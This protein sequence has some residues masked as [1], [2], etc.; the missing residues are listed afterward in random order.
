M[1][2]YSEISNRY[3]KENKKRT[4]LTIL[5]ITLATVL[6]FAVGTFL[7]SFKDS[8]IVSERAKSDY[9]FQVRN[10]NSEQAEKVVNNAEVKDSSVYESGEEYSLSAINRKTVLEKG[11]KDYFDKIYTNKVLEGRE[12]EK[13]GEVI[14]DVNVKNILRTK[15]GDEFT[16]TNQEGKI[17]KINIVGISEQKIYTSNGPLVFTGY[18]DNFDNSKNYYI[19]VNL[20]SDKSKQQII[21]KVI[22]TANIEVKDGTKINNSEL[23]YLTGNGPAK[24]ITESL[25][26]MAVFVIVIIMLCTITVIYNSFN[27]SV[28]ERIKY[29]GILKAIGATPKQIK[30][31]IL[32]EGAIMGV[33]A[34][35][36]GCLIGYFSLVIGVKLF[37][38]DSLI[39]VD[40]FKV[41]FYPSIIAVTVALVSVTIWIS[42]LGPA[43]KA[44]KVSA[45]EAMRNKNE[46]KIGKVKRRRGKLVGKIFGIEGSLA[47]KNI[48][49]TPVRFIIT[50]V[51]LTISIIM[52]NVFY[53]F[54]DYAKQYIYQSYGNIFFDSQLGK[55]GEEIFTKN[56]V[57]DIESKS[58]IKNTYEFNLKN[59]KIAISKDYINEDFIEKTGFDKGNEEVNN[60]NILSRINTYI[61]GD[62]ELG[63][64]EKY[65]SEGKFDLE[66]LKNG[67]IILIDGRS[68]THK[69]GTKE[70]VR[71]TNYKVGDK[72]RIPKLNN[73]D[74]KSQ[75][76]SDE[77]IKEAIENNKYYEVPIIAIAQ[78]EPFQGQFLT[79]D[80]VELMIHKDAYNKYFKD[81]SPNGLFFTFDGDKEAREEA[82]K[83]FDE[84]KDSKGYNYTD[85]GSS[86]NQ[87][88]QLFKQA[89][90]FVYCF[91]I[92]ITVISIVNIFNT[93]ST[94]LLLRKKEFATLKAIGMMEKQLRKSVILEGTLYGI[95]ASIVGGIASALLLGLLIKL[96]GGIGDLDYKFGII[97]FVASIVAAIAVTYLSTLIPLRRLKKLTIIEGISDDE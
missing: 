75:E 19:Y 80:E 35:P 40:N 1:K 14:I 22:K 46:I 74:Y 23:L 97:P 45:V 24:G 4:A 11:N 56:E 78:K 21:D 72:I 38:G 58:F 64:E 37:I 83:Y 73:Y 54:L 43:R 8:M 76:A 86:M 91:I 60:Y 81:F 50:V 49:R 30:R 95:I 13:E 28:I 63:I 87:I 89:E 92:I 16:L 34:L 33:I 25:Y 55:T 20:K 71:F 32:K 67:G 70:I 51:A 15:V 39:F 85:L 36:L 6:I 2:S 10:I 94:N 82:I 66:G 53:G 17:T 84:V 47:Y 9:E 69:D 3:M 41:Q 62:K 31:I 93:I 68:I 90:F 42:I 29:F 18:T 26:K 88:N 59:T 65:I 48:R 57:N 77:K 96:G 79:E 12:P 7:F 44:R 27:I 52:F 5:G 61:G